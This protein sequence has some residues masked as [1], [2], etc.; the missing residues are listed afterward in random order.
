M[1]EGGTDEGDDLSAATREAV[2]RARRRAR[3]EVPTPD[4][5]ADMTISAGRADLSRA[6]IRS[7]AAE[8]ISNL[9]R[10]NYL[11]GRLTELADDEA[12]P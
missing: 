5:L 7:L 6:E 8:A 2:S 11:L 4:E 1:T 9:Q 12:G 10:I 3:E